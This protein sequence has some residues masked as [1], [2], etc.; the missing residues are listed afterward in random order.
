MENALWKFLPRGRRARIA[1]A[2]VAGGFLLAGI[3]AAAYAA[4]QDG[5]GVIHACVDGKGA[6]RIIDVAVDA[7]KKGETAIS[8][9]QT[10]PQGPAGASGTPGAKGDQGSQGVAG[11]AGAAGPPGAGGP[12]GQQ[13]VQGPQGVAGPA[14]PPGAS[15]GGGSAPN[16]QVIGVVAIDTGGGTIDNGGQPIDVLGYSWGL[17]NTSDPVGGGGGGGKTIPTPFKFVKRVDAASPSL[18]LVAARGQRLESVTVTIFSP[19]SSSQV[20]QKL[21]F[22]D[23]GIAVRT[24]AHTGAVGDIPLE[25]ISI[26]FARATEEVGGVRGAWDFFQN[27]GV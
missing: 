27:K 22:N 26:N 11:P 17:T 12:P 10:G 20:L 18:F 21:T 23:C 19:G 6:T 25:E 2:A 24:E 1:L 14:G 3:G 7:C 15:G 9:N 5:S 8:W 13:G 4:L 16:K